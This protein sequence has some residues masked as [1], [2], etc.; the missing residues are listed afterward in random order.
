[1]NGERE[2][3]AV[4]SIDPTLYRRK[5]LLYLLRTYRFSPETR[6]VSALEAVEAYSSDNKSL[7][8]GE[9]LAN[10]DQQ[11]AECGLGDLLHG[12]VQQEQ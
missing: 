12:L 9:T 4:I 10:Q 1:M 8:Q 2:L 3:D 11:A 7:Y 6:Q 5:F